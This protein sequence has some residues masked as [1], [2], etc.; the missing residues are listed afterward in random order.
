MSDPAI[1]ILP[2]ATP[3]ALPTVDRPTPPRSGERDRLVCEFCECQLTP[4]G[5]IIRYSERGK[6]FRDLTFTVAERDRKL[7][8]LEGELTRLRAENAA[9]LAE[10]NQNR[11]AAGKKPWYKAAL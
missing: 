4:S 9:L 2:P 10:V 8:E 11:A 7:G 6:K 5:E 1:D 3:A